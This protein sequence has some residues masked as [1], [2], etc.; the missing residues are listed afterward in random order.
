MD[1]HEEK[2]N[3]MFWNARS[4]CKKQIETHNYL[5]DNNIQIALISETWCKKTDNIKFP[6]Y[7]CYRLDREGNRGG[8]V[9]ILIRKE[10]KHQLLPDLRL[11]VIES[12][13]ISITV[14]GRNLNIFSVYYPGARRAAALSN[15]RNDIRVLTAAGSGYIIC[16]DLNSRHRSWNC[17]RAN[18]AGKVLFEENCRG[19]FVINFPHSPTYY[20]S[21]S[22]STPSTLD[23]MLTNGLC[24]IS[25]LE[26][27]NDLSSD[28]CPVTFSIG[29][30]SV[31][32][33]TENQIPCYNRADWVLFKRFLHNSISLNNLTPNLLQ[34]SDIDSMVEFLTGKIQEAIDLSVPKVN[35]FVFQYVL[36]ESIRILI[37]FRNARRR[38]WQR[39]RNHYLGQIVS[40]LNQR[41]RVAI[42]E[43]RNN[44][45]A[46]LLSTIRTTNNQFW[47][48]T[49]ILKKRQNIIPTLID[50]GRKVFSDQEKLD[51]IAH[52]FSEAHLLTLNQPVTPTLSQ[53]VDEKIEEIHSSLPV[54]VEA[55]ELTSPREIKSVI[56]KLGRRKT[57]GLDKI[58]NVVLKNLPRKVL[59]FITY[60]FN[61]CLMNQYFPK[62]WK[63]AT[64]VAIP[65]P[66][67]DL[68]DPKNYRPISLLCA[69]SKVFERII[70]SRI[71]NH[72][73]GQNVLPDFQFGFRPQHST[74]HQVLRIT[75]HIKEGFRAKLSTGMFLLDIEK[76][77]DTVWHDGLLYKMCLKNFPMYQV[78][79]VCSFLSD[80]TFCVI[81]KG[82]I[83][84]SY[85]IPAGLPQGAAL[86][87]TLYGIF[88]SDPPELP[89]C[90]IATFADDTAI[91]TTHSNV[92]LIID[93]LQDSIEKLHQYFDS[94]K[95]KINPAKSQC[96]YFTKRRSPRYLPSSDLIIRN[97][98]IAWS[99]DVKYLGVIMD[100]KL[101]FSRHIDYTLQ[102]T[103]KMFKIFYSILNRRSRM[104]VK[105][106]LTLYKVALR[107]ILIYCCPV[108]KTCALTHRNKIQIMQ[109]KF[110]KT[111]LNLP[112][113]TSTQ[114][115][116]E[117]AEILPI[118]ELVDEISTKFENRCSFANNPLIQSLY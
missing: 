32:Y 105:N 29:A 24:S 7:H 27:H 30:S 44:E 76:A 68:S 16:G 75:K 106:K 114:E 15:F 19:N 96:I 17:A 62:K 74:C 64:V 116:H 90:D 53:R 50:N 87:P 21:N 18:G 66:G 46:T 78:R 72:I 4:I 85:P 77:F 111:I 23:I 95:I 109:N 35:P 58:N 63:H 108:W 12:I 101:L 57:P 8:G 52:K 11:T 41:I 67:K 104:I 59:V 89:N 115:V 2:I 49:K 51:I 112:W 25:E 14:N 97:S 9:A 42:Q 56:K 6:N 13:G 94:W 45:W 110:L 37:R 10:I 79:L 118:N 55:S 61:A 86:S 3:L 5:I 47:Q 93:R 84:G 92:N 80:R 39:N 88:T 48:T 22:N 81:Y 40:Y 43:F 82:L 1:N 70:L 69:L 113:Y 91:Y 71:S 33:I 99:D 34:P 60:L 38:Q 100:K 107:S 31:D 20:P 83:S 102:K 103:E 36:P 54:E 28:H 26:V 117:L 65:K 98:T 73:V